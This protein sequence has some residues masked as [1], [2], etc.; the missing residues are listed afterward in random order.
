MKPQDLLVARRTSLASVVTVSAGDKPHLDAF[1]ARLFGIDRAL[2]LMPSFSFVCPDDL[3]VIRYEGF[4]RVAQVGFGL[5]SGGLATSS[6]GDIFISGVTRLQ[7]RQGQ[8]L[9]S[10]ASDDLAILGLADG[11]ASLRKAGRNVSKNL[12]EWLISLVDSES[13][14]GNWLARVRSLAGD[15]LG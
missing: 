10:L 6:A 8:K 11:L 7:Q 15:L 3:E 12:P 9:Q 4:P 13:W 14:Q 5:G 1:V 2:E